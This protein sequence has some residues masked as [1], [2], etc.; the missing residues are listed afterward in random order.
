MLWTIFPALV[1]VIAVSFQSCD[2]KT[3][4]EW[5]GRIIYQVPGVEVV[6]FHV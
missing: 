4:E 3:A 6:G 5:K 2:G 1:V